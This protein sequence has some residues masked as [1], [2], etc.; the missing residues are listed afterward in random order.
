MF[1]NTPK[2]QEKFLVFVLNPVPG[3]KDNILPQI[4]Y[5]N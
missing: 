1:V 3:L 5:A 4:T 2:M